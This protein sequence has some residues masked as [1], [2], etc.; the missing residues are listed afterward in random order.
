[1]FD[2]T[3]GDWDIE[4][5]NL[6]L[7]PGYKPFNSKYYP[8]PRN[9]KETLRKELKRLVKIRVLTLVQQSQYGTPIFITPKK[10]GTVRFITYY[11][12][13]NQIL[14]RKPH[15][16]PRIG[17]TTQLLKLFQYVTTLDLSMGYY[18]IR[19]PPT[20]QDMAT[21]VTEFG[22]FRYNRLPIGRCASGDIFQA[23]V[24]ELLGDIEGVK[25]Y[26]DDTLVL[27]RDLFKNHIDQLKMIFDRL[28][29]AGLKDNSPK[30][31]FRLKEIPYLGYVIT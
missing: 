14:V 20:S 9:N 28:R 1:M 13:L 27:S 3:L 29:D 26:I 8:A 23:R 21:I 19:L 24:D 17:D 2:G 7:K 31:I 12:R 16:L 10:E 11:R 22:K 4:P 18:T 15:P 5:V 30:C 6:E 25:T